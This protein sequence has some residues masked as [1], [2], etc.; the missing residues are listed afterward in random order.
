MTKPAVSI[1]IPAYNASEFIGETLTSV[2]ALDYPP[3]LLEL[4]VVDDGSTDDTV[5]EVRRFLRSSPFQWQVVEQSNAGPARARNIGWRSAQR[6]WIQFLDA[7]DLLDATKLQIQTETAV[8]AKLWQV[9]VVTHSGSG[10]PNTAACGDRLMRFAIPASAK[11]PFL[12]SYRGNHSLQTGS[13][14]AT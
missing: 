8:K 2:V 12:T 4:I 10:L 5:D 7:D 14:M 3:A 6:E 9:A 1:V 11:M 13:A